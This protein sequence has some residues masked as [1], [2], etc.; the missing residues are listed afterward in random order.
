MSEFY[1]PE[2]SAGYRYDDPGLAIYWPLPLAVISA[3]DLTWPA[4]S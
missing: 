2:S 4:F 3:Q 1:D